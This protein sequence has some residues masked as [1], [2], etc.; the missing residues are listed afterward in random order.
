[1]PAL[2]KG[3]VL[4][5]HVNRLAPYHGTGR[6]TKVR[7]IDDDVN[8]DDD[9]GDDAA[10]IIGEERDLFEDLTIPVERSEL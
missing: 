7:Y 2:T 8:L 4:K 10:E 3:K 5:V 6:H 1:M 9:V